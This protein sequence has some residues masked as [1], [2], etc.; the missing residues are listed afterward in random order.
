MPQF[1]RLSVWLVRAAQ[2]VIK[3]SHNLAGAAGYYLM[4]SP[5]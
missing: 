3:V 4:K 1:Q 5:E 2:A